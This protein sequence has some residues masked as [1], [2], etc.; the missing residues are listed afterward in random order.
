VESDKVMDG[1]E[2][3][4]HDCLNGWEWWHSKKEMVTRMKNG[5]EQGISGKKD[6]VRGRIVTLGMN[7]RT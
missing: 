7:G 6:R 5:G 3:G 4:K 1:K 2:L